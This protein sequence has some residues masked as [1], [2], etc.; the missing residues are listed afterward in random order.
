MKLTAKDKQVTVNARA[1]LDL[2]LRL[3]AGPLRMRKLVFLILDAEFEEILIGRHL[4]NALRIDVERHLNEVRMEYHEEDFSNVPSL[5][6]GASGSLS[7]ALYAAVHED[8]LDMCLSMDN[9]KTD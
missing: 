8:P 7:R 1:Q 5:A 6:P 4:M 9:P 2:N 3:A